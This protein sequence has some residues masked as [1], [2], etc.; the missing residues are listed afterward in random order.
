MMHRLFSSVGIVLLCAG[1]LIGC[2][3]ITKSVKI[4]CGE[5]YQIEEEQLE[6]KENLIWESEDTSVVDVSDNGLVTAK[7]PGKAKVN[8][9]D[10]EKLVGQYTFNVSIVPI[11]Q[12]VFSTDTLKITDGE[13]KPLKYTLLPQNASD[14]GITW[15]S[16]DTTVANILVNKNVEI[17]G[18]GEGQTTIIAT[19]DNGVTAQFSV[20]VAPKSAYDQLNKDEKDFVDAILPIM[21]RFKNPSSVRFNAIGSLLNDYIFEVAAQNGFGGTGVQT[22]YYDPNADMILEWTGTARNEMNAELITRAVHEK[23]GY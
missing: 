23:L 9:K 1:L 2:G 22:Y 5:T 8:V 4:N 18:Q 10:G 16:A 14:Y 19:T 17:V 12:I 20:E 15:T 11:E 6:Q 21:N 3:K 13:K 7:A